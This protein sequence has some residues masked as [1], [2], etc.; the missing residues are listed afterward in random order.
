MSAHSAAGVGC[1][2][3]EAEDDKDA[4][5]ACSED[6]SEE[7]AASDAADCD[8]ASDALP[9]AA[10]CAAIALSAADARSEG[11]MG[12]MA[13]N[14]GNTNRKVETLLSHSVFTP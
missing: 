11:P 14:N 8:S 7:S 13:E 1:D 3:D 6:V 10:R 9:T 5:E 4:D 2:D 12:R